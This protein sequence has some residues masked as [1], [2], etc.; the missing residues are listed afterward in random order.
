MR[1]LLLLT[2]APLAATAAANGA[3]GVLVAWP[4]GREGPPS[5]AVALAFGLA[6]A[7]LYAAGMALND[8]FDL[9]RDRELYPN[10]PLPSG[11]VQPRTGALIGAGL[12]GTGVLLAAAFGAA[13]GERRARP[14]GGRRGGGL[15][16]GA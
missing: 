1:D 15:G 11:R 6:S 2:R 9:A 5:L 12:L 4:A 10:R 16:P 7:C 3:L 8:W 14:D 13:F